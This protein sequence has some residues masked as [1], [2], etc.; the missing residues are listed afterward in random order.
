MDYDE[1]GLYL[2]LN[3]ND[4]ELRRIGLYNVCPKR[5]RDRGPRPRLTCCGMKENRNERHEPWEFPNLQS[6]S[7]ETKRKMFVE[8]MRI[9]LKALMETH[10]Y[11]FAGVIRRQ[12]NGGAIGMELT[13]VVAQV[14]MV[15]WDK[16]FRK[17]LQDVE[18]PLDKV[19]ERYVDDTN[20][21]PRKTPI[22]ARYNG[23]RI[24]ITEESIEEDRGVADDKRTMV[25]LQ[26]I[27]SYI[28]P[29]I[30][31]T[32]DYPS[33]YDDGKVPM[34]SLKMWIGNVEH[35]TLI[36]YEHYEKPM[37]T[38][39]VVH[40]NSAIPLTMKRTILTQEALRIL[41]HCSK[42]LPWDIPR[43]HM[44]NLM[45]KIQYSGYDKMFRYHVVNGAM[46]A[47]ERLR[48]MERLGVRP[49]HRPKSWEVERRRKEKVE[50]KKGWYKEGGFDSV[51][52]VSMTPNSEL[53][54]EYEKEI[55]KSGLRIKV[56]ERTGRTLKSQ[57]QCSD[58]FR[59][60]HCGR[61][62]CLVCTTS[63]NGNCQAEN[64]TYII[65]CEA[66][67]CERSGKYKGE[68][69]NNTYTRGKKHI[70]DYNGQD[71]DKSPLWRH[72]VD[73][74]NGQRQQ[75]S[76]AVTKTFRYD[77]MIR[78]I[79]EAVQIRN[80]EP[81]ELMNTRAEWNLNRIPRAAIHAE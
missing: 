54:K 69:H 4:D 72:C 13:G 43:N 58:P 50:K 80:T 39:C 18:L 66:T 60:E 63:G 70:I 68:T 65:K 3:R 36:L 5:R 20:L 29:S 9:V 48:E 23:E 45:K 37:A 21:V 47:Y 44:N 51:L 40:K 11:T 26:S 25:L 76:M 81:R 14:F 73:V 62:D 78:Q 10:T 59:E 71:I 46:K 55:K 52:F 27:G 32:I 6:T 17:R 61:L 49:V 74:H 56:V 41:L 53:K 16:Q 33:K 34:L 22:G 79:S 35:R 2:S 12:R 7:E 24:V 28:H 77:S 15:W 31:S 30:R 38:K 57:L 67:V 75:F 1:L 8:A 64:A 19:H 42:H